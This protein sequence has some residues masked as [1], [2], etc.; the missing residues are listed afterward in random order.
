MVRV[1]QKFLPDP[2]ITKFRKQIYADDND[3]FLI[4]AGKRGSTKSGSGIRF[5]HDIDMTTPE[6]PEGI[7]QT[8]FYLDYKYYPEHFKLKQGE[9]LP[10]VIYKPSQLLDML[11]NNEKYPM[12][13]CVLWDEVG[14]G[15]DARDFAKQKNKLLK[16]TFQTVRSLNWFLILTAVTVKDFDV[17]FSR[18]A[19]F[20][21]QMAGKVQLKSTIGANTPQAYGKGKLYEIDVDPRTAKSLYKYLR[22]RDVDSQYKVLSGWYYVKRPP[23][24]M[25]TP[26]K[27]YKR[28]FQTKLYSS[29]ARE[30]DG[31]ESFELNEETTGSEQSLIDNKIREIQNN[32]GDYYDYNKKRF[33]LAAVQFTGDLK[34]PTES[35]ARKVVELLNFKLKKGEI[36][37]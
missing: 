4:I 21:M 35:K 1:R 33:V 29:Y 14:V 19:G 17:A 13:T 3:V 28:L 10:R 15:G 36:I 32:V 6:H 22:Y 20:Y 31:I 34:I 16:K 11:K 23:S 37:V 30:L 5:G 12:G 27:R 7:P 25:E 24:Y 18:A 26:Y 8:R 2:V 9:F